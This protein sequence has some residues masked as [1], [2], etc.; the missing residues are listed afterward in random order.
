MSKETKKWLIIAGS[1]VILGLIMFAVVMTI[2]KWDFTKLSTMKIETNTYQVTELFSNMS[3]K[4]DTADIGF[5]VS[6]D[7]KC[8]VVCNEMEKVKHSVS[9]QNGTLSIKAVDERNWFDYIR[10]NFSK[11]QI[12]VY[13][14]QNE[15]ESL[16]I[17]SST[18]N[19]R[20]E[21]ISAGALDLSASTGRIT[22]S[23]VK[24]DG[25]IKINVTTGQTNLT[26]VNC[27]NV[28]SSGS[29]GSMVLKNVIATEDYSIERTTG[30]VKFDSCDARE[31]SI[32]TSTGNISGT[33]LS[34]K[35][36]I[37]ETSTGNVDVPKT[38]TGGKCEL[39]TSTGNI[40]VDS[41]P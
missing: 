27:K 39:K 4:T 26:N 17:S 18:G 38:T 30:N 6:D 19:I 11:T 9:I 14:P 32:R 33:L 25:D 1:L 20:I 16:S 15:Y 22:V 40:K 31:I 34:E 28:I 12:T 7:G 29:T 8:K 5:A 21:N 24:C 41:V 3:I 23:D 37:A 10:I 36:F 35:L 13:L 2:L